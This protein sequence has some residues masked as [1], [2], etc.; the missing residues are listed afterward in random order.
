MTFKNLESWSIMFGG[1]LWS[2]ETFLYSIK[3]PLSVLNH[4]IELH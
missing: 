4:L 3:H 2:C 1:C